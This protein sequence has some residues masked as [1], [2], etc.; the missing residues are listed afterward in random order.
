MALSARHPEPQH[1]TL[2]A[3][4]TETM[5]QPSSFSTAVRILPAV[6][7]E[8]ET[9]NLRAEARRPTL[10]STRVTRENLKS[11]LAVAV[12]WEK[13]GDPAYYVGPN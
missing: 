11:Q 3:I 4:S 13:T 8:V 5:H 9:P 1:Y 12:A 2:H 7:P 6:S 10:S